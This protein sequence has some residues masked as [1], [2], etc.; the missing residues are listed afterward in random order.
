MKDP[1]TGINNRRAFDAAIKHS[2]NMHFVLS[3]PL[4]LV[5]VDVDHFKQ[6]N[7]QYGHPA[8]DDV[9]RSVAECLERSFVRR[10]DLVGALHPI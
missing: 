2:V 9:L 7:D 6:I 10:G 3:Q 1:L 4:T 8:G 5:L